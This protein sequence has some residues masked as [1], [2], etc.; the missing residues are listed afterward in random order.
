MWSG[1]AHGQHVAVHVYV[2]AELEQVAGDAL[3]KR[4]RV[5]LLVVS[6]VVLLKLVQDC[7]VKI[8]K[9]G[10]TSSLVGWRDENPAFSVIQVP[11]CPSL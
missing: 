10:V 8:Q 7:S 1:N 6:L 5:T 9:V 4:A 3:Q 11:R 2:F